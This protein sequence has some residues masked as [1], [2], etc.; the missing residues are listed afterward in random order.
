MSL[1]EKIENNIAMFFLGTIITGFLAGIGTYK[2]ILEIA[3]LEVVHKNSVIKK[4]DSSIIINR[5][6]E[7]LTNDDYEVE[8]GAKYA[9]SKIGEPAIPLLIKALEGGSSELK[10]EAASLLGELKAKSA[11][12]SLS[13]ALDD[14]DQYVRS[15]AAIAL[16]DIGDRNYIRQLC[17]AIKDEESCVRAS[18]AIALGT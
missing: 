5:F 7:D 12:E 11:S 16:G 18:A 9:I 3:K 6:I 10:Q 13:N 4:D 15:A 14:K 2:A 1:K 17:I 8:D